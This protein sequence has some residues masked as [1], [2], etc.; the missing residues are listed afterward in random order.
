[1]FLS[2]LC[3]TSQQFTCFNASTRECVPLSQKCDGVFNC[4]G[5]E[6]EQ[7][8]CDKSLFGC[9]VNASDMFD[10][11]YGRTGNRNHYHCLERYV[12]CN[13]MNDCTDG[14]DETDCKLYVKLY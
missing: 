13:G 1:M 14:S 11:L 12:I 7:V 8:C 9:Y 6:D 3:N 2:G 10:P 5:K 4:Q